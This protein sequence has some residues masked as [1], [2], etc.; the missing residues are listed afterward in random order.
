MYGTVN[1]A[2]YHPMHSADAD[3]DSTPAMPVLESRSAALAYQSRVTL[4]SVTGGRGSPSVGA[5]DIQRVTS[6]RACPSKSASACCR[7]SS[8]TGVSPTP[9]SMSPAAMRPQRAAALPGVTPWTVN[10]PAGEIL[11]TWMPMPFETPAPGG[12]DASLAPMP[13]CPCRRE[14]SCRTCH[15]HQQVWRHSFPPMLQNTQVNAK[16]LRAVKVS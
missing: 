4:T 5:L 2:G 12:A 14:P 11:S 8:Y 7:S 13:P 1:D 9:C 16:P 3:E 15:H 10:G 6:E